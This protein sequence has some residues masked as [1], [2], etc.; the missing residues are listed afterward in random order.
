MKN[1]ILEKTFWKKQGA[2]N[3]AL[4]KIYRTG[5]N[6]LEKTCNRAQE[7]MAKYNPWKIDIEKPILEK[8]LWKKHL[9]IVQEEKYNSWKRKNKETWSKKNIGKTSRWNHAGKQLEKYNDG[10]NGN[11][12]NLKKY[13]WRKPRNLAT[14]IMEKRNWCVTEKNGSLEKNWKLNRNDT[15]NFRKI[16]QEVG[17]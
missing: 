7:K 2:G 15:C 14:K 1:A 13:S 9:G 10:K 16:T 17:K 12:Y 11:K 5:K 8:T 3:T 6:I 4:D